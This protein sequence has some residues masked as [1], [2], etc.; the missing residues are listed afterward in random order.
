VEGLEEELDGH[1]QRQRQAQKN[2]R[3]DQ[4]DV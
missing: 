2:G 1:D 4:R 3:Q